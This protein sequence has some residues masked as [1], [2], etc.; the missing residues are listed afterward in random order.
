MDFFPQ[1]FLPDLSPEEVEQFVALGKEGWQLLRSR[2]TQEAEAAFQSQIA[3]CPVNPEPYVSLALL[4]A[5]RH[6][7]KAAVEYLRKAVLRGFRDMLRVQRAE[8]WGGMP[9]SPAFMYLQDTVHELAKAERNW[10]EWK[11]ES[12]WRPPQDLQAFLQGHSALHQR[13]ETMAPAMG[14]RYTEL[15]RRVLDHGAAFQIL[16]YVNEHPQAKDIDFALEELMQLLTRRLLNRWDVL[17]TESAQLLAKVS[18]TV[19]DR[20]P[21]GDL[22]QAA[23]VGLALS[24]NSDR[25][26]DGALRPQS[27]RSIHTA[28]E[29]VAGAD[30]DSP[31]IPTATVGL[32]RLA[33]DAGAIEQAGEYYG[34]FRESH[35]ENQELLTQ[36][37]NELGE[38]VLRMNGLPEFQ[39]E[40]IGGKV[41]DPATLRGKIILFDFWATWCRPCVEEFPTLRRI[42]KK[43]AGEFE[44]IG[45]NLD[46]GDDF[47]DE[48][49]RQ[50]IHQEK[51]PGT[52]IHDGLAWDSILVQSFGV[53]EIPFNVLVGAEGEIIAINSHGKQLEHL[54][55]NAVRNKAATK[56]ALND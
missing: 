9:R 17:P 11:R 20:S 54:V 13:I 48:G 34:R 14:E 46:W 12:H 43:Y 53:Q 40:A 41:V 36:V 31:L 28:L 4:E 56:L 33:A 10:P 27:A 8:A 45:V 35:A 52:Q 50:W 5:N 30:T 1:G 49:L 23:L 39:I 24:Q 16:S 22:R 42:Q 6:S 32:I 47:A 29:E 37:Q 26:E 55:R 38:L 7:H 21:Q 15:W 19:L 2:K 18:Q 51:V 25:T 3:I 44:L